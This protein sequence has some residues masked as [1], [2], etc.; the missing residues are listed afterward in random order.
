[1]L[2]ALLVLLVVLVER[3]LLG[4]YN[5]M[6]MAV[7]VVAG[8]AALVVDHFLAGE[9]EVKFQGLVLLELIMVAGVQG[10]VRRLLLAVQ[11]LAVL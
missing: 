9:V 6:E 7:A 2:V 11:V 3:V 5:L 8:A 4:H 10:V 1:M